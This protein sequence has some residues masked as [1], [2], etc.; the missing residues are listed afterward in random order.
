MGRAS[1][2]ALVSSLPQGKTVCVI[3]CEKQAAHAMVLAVHDLMLCALLQ[4]SD[5][6]LHHPSHHSLLSL[7][8]PF[9]IAGDR[10]REMYYWDR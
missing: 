4:T 8:N 10:F 2:Q 6:V 5:D 3:V 7:N 9:I 1:V